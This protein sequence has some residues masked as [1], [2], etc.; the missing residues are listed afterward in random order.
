MAAVGTRLSGRRSP[1][2]RKVCNMSDSR[3]VEYRKLAQQ[4][5]AAADQAFDPMAGQAFLALAAQWERLAEEAEHGVRY[6]AA[7]SDNAAHR[8]ARPT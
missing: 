2:Q 5:L 3:V 8:P 7:K 6:V 1:T 4:M